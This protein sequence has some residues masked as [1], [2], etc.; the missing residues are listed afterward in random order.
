MKNARKLTDVLRDPFVAAEDEGEIYNLLTMEVM[1]E[2][3]S[4]DILE[5]DKI[6]QRMLVKF[7]TEDL[8]EWDGWPCVWDKM[9]KKNLK[10]FKTTNAVIDM[11]AGGKFVKIK[12][13]RGLLERLIVIWRSRPQ[14]D[15]KECIGTYEFG[16]VPHSLFA[17]D[18]TVV[19]AYDKAKILHHIELLVSTVTGH[20]HSSH[21]NIHEYCL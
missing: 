11:N 9:A 15:L 16:V 6:G 10:T 20:A 4:K 3:V 18:G 13:E 2:N 17:L 7:T 19:L 5:G 1:T 12:Q 8:T 21:G 14:L